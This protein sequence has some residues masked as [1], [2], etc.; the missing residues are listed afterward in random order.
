MERVRLDA[1]RDL[2]KQVDGLDRCR[3][4]ENSVPVMLTNYLI[5]GII[6][7]GRHVVNRV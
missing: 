2:K 6:R 7:R 1:A 3:V 5:G 4:V